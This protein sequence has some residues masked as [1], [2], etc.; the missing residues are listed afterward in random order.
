ME[1]HLIR[2]LLNEYEA[3]GKTG[4]PIAMENNTLNV[5]FGLSLIQILDLDERNQVL[6][7]NVW[8][9]YV[10]ICLLLSESIC[11]YAFEQPPRC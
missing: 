5:S 9:S 11:I 8:A 2:T 4:R 3:R 1:K 6:S 7:T 10:S